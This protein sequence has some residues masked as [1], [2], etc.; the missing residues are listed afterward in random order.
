MIKKYKRRFNS[1]NGFSI[2]TF[3]NKVGFINNKTDLVIGEIKYDY[4]ENFFE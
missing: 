2:I 1:V 4:A 3:N